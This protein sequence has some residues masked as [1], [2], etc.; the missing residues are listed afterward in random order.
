MERKP[1]VIQAVVNAACEQLQAE[2]KNVTVNAVVGICGGS[3]STVGD[4]VKLWR[5]EQAAHSAP[6]L[7]M[8]DSVTATM[9]KAA[10]DIW[11]AAS[12]LAGESVERIQHEAGEAIT[13][14]KAELA[15]YAGEVSRL[16]REL[17]QAHIKTLEVKHSL[18]AAQEKAVKI[19]RENAG[20]VAQLTEKDHQLIS[21]KADYAKLQSELVEI[22]KAATK[23]ARKPRA[24][25][26]PKKAAE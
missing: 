24:K 13:K 21:L 7:Q 22:A 6:L 19:T 9:H 14:A 8:P 17:E 4:M 3:F 1:K 12:T 25:A 18:D 23:P 2:S 16:E 20:Y 5:E 10:F 15:E 11:A 26:T